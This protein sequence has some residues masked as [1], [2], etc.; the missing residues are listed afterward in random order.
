MRA[1]VKEMGNS[2]RGGDRFSWDPTFFAVL[3]VYPFLLIKRAFPWSGFSRTP[4]RF[5]PVLAVGISFLISAAVS[6]RM[7]ALFRAGG[8]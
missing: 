5:A 3:L 6:W 2:L 1:T 8:E 7:L 4:L